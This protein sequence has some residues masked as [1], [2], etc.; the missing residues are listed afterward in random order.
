MNEYKS[1]ISKLTDQ[2]LKN[3]F[4]YKDVAQLIFFMM[5][6]LNEQQEDQ[7][8]KFM[9]ATEEFVTFLEMKPFSTMIMLYKRKKYMQKL[10]PKK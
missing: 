9:L 6:Y 4:I 3:N 5:Y 1:V 10:S 8:C 7:K 2:I